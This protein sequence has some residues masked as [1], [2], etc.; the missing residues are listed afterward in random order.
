VSWVLILVCVGDSPAAGDH[1]YAVRF[2]S[3]EAAE[4][5]AAFFNN[6]Q[7]VGTVVTQIIHDPVVKADGEGRP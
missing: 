7:R 6:K 5:A 3:R 2:Y 4:Q 1:P